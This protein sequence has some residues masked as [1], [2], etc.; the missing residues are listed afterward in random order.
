M[1]RSRL[2]FVLRKS[3]IWSAIVAELETLG[4]DTYALE[5]TGKHPVVRIVVNGREKR[6]SFSLTPG[7][8][9]GARTEAI[10]AVRRFV[11]E[12]RAC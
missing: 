7:G 1:S 8:R 5:Y 9:C 12:A 11:R 2:H 3:G 4:V 6:I 10:A